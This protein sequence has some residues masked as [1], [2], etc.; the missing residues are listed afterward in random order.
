VIRFFIALVLIAAAIA[1]GAFFAGNP[2]E[3]RIVWQ[4]WRIDTSVGVLIGAAA[5]LALVV[6]VLAL[7]VAALRRAPRNFR[8]RHADRRRRR[9]EAAL[10]RGLVALAA[11]DAGEAGRQAGRA[12]ALLGNSP[13]VL[14]IA[15]EAAQRQGD[16]A[17]ARHAYSVLRQQ[18]D[19]EFLGLRG[20]LG[21]ALRAGDDSAAL[22][23]AERAQR[24]RP[25]AGW[26]ADSV[27]L[28]QARSGDWAAVQETLAAA[29]RRGALAADEA[30]HG[31]GVALYELSR[32]T[33]RD[34]DLRRAAGLAA[35]AQALAPDLAPP[36]THHARLLAGLGR[37]RAATKALERAWRAAP[38]PELASAYAEIVGGS[39]P[40]DRAA[41]LHKLAELE[42]PATEG[43]LAAGEAALDAQLW[44][45]ARRH[46]DLALAA[47][48]GDGRPSRRLCLAMA[49]L[50]EA[51]S[52][53]LAAA[54]QWLDRAIAA[55]RAPAYACR[56]CGVAAERWQ[57]LCPHCGSFDTLGWRFSAA[58]ATTS[59]TLQA[60]AAPM[61]PA[62][63][64]ATGWASMRPGLAAV[65]R[66]DK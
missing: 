37:R 41:A 32:R 1:A 66:S 12:T 45:E 62:P 36:A 35:K 39:G 53:D 17:A 48:S 28:L 64:G 20:L 13:T 52:G 26:L 29:T 25:A 6:A 59:A 23:L 22:P 11:G 60:A 49:R 21:Q 5:L 18:P 46:L 7:I 42:P 33:E 57:P 2:G 34:G 55:P 8:R 51:G 50:A 19:S 58:G 30:H 54:R 44:G 56:R 15:A 47:G 10:T 9:G 3:V 31:R 63:D 38:H 43:R 24:L 65:A 16:E 61:L 14:L 4:G 27:V 40:L